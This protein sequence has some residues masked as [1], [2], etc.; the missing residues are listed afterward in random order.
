MTDKKKADQQASPKKTHSHDT[1]GSAQR[2]RLLA[3]LRLGPVDTFTAI[4]ELNIVRPGARIAEL[5][6]A[7]HPIKT[8]RITITDD[9]G[10]THEGIALY[11][12]SITLAT[13]AP[14]EA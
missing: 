4:R 13:P 9:Q 14:A 11:F 5:R 12:L 2:L 3:R 7:G 10:R 1:S 8:Q 6:A